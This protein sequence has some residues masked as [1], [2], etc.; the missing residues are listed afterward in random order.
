MAECDFKSTEEKIR[1]LQEHLRKYGDAIPER[2]ILEATSGQNLE[3]WVME[4]D[5]KGDIA[6]AI[7]WENN[8]W[9]LC[10]MHYLA[11]ASEQRGKGLGKKV[12]ARAVE[13]AKGNPNCLVLAADV[14]YNNEPSKRIFRGLGFEEKSRFC[15]APGEKPADIL[16][17]VKFPPEGATC[18]R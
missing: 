16:H 15:W 2:A 5:D 17:F 3:N 18:K 12:A 4:C 14:T 6:S 1:K 11:T 7:T 10:T 8:D 9:F 13:S